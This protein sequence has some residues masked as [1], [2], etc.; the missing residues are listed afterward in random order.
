MTSYKSRLY[1]VLA[2]ILC[3]VIFIWIFFKTKSPVI[4]PINAI[5]V[6]SSI[7]IEF[8]SGGKN[9]K[10]TLFSSDFWN[11][12][13]NIKEFSDFKSNIDFVDSL[14]KSKNINLSKN[15]IY[16]SLLFDENK[17]MNCLWILG[18]NTNDYNS[19]IED[20]F[21]K[22][23]DKYGKLT[24][25]FF[26][27]TKVFDFEHDNGSKFSFS[28]FKGLILYSSSSFLVNE[29]IKQTESS[30]IITDDKYF[31]KIYKTAGKKVDGNL[32]VNLN[33]ASEILN[34]IS[35]DTSSCSIFN[36]IASWC[37][38]D[39]NFKKDAILLNGFTNVTDTSDS[40]LG[41]FYNQEPQDINI[42]NIL[43]DNA[44]FFQYYGFSDFNL[45]YD[46][47]S[48][49]YYK[50]LNNDTLYSRTDSF[51][52]KI[53]IN[54]KRNLFSWIV[55]EV[56]YMKCKSDFEK[57]LCNSYF[58][59]KSKDV[60]LSKYYLSE[61]NENSASILKKKIDT[62]NY[63]G[64]KLCKM[65]LS[66]F[67]KHYFGNFLNIDSTIYT[68][69]NN[70]AVFGNSVNSL[71]FI[72]DKNI[73]QK[74][75][76]SNIE[77][78]DFSNLIS[79][80][81]NVYLYF[82]FKN[83][84]ENI[85]TDTTLIFNDFLKSNVSELNNFGQFS[86]QF[87]SNND[88]Y[89]SNL[90]LKQNTKTEEPT[91]DLW[92]TQFDTTLNKGPY[93]SED[94]QGNKRIM[95]VDA[96]NQIYNVDLD[97]KIK[98]KKQIKDS[99]FSDIIYLNKGKRQFYLFNTINKIHMLDENGNYYNNYPIVLDISANNGITVSDFDNSKD[100]RIYFVGSDNVIYDYKLS[101]EKV[102]DWNYP[103]ID[104]I[105]TKKLN[106]YTIND[107]AYIISTDI[108]G[109]L[110]FFDR[111]GKEVLR[112]MPS[113]ILGNNSSI[114]YYNDNESGKIKLITT[115]SKGMVYKLSNNYR[116]ESIEFQNFSSEHYFLYADFNN[117]K[118]EDCIFVDKN[119][120]TI[121]D[122]NKNIIFKYNTNSD[123]SEAPKK[124][125]M[126]NNINAF[127]FVAR[128]TKEIYIIESFGII[129]KGFP[130][131]GRNIEIYNSK[132]NNSCNILIIN[133]NYL[134]NYAY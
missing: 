108:T 5:P 53:N 87:S 29:A 56:T 61:I 23:C 4:K 38:L 27:K 64:Y 52:K 35:K 68:F 62:L 124:F 8:P 79:S 65:P 51:M 127:T 60:N 96:K 101:S 75:L 99:I 71:K 54:I 72:I 10:N 3:L 86:I 14:I 80:N 31:E 15:N 90:C 36:K 30:A 47:Y 97:G 94:R 70:Y 113:I 40:Y 115:D 48:K 123:I 20:L 9:I 22:S 126:N 76:S 55:S 46:K 104:N 16:L 21:E 121:I 109:K 95:V 43:P 131:K 42:V 74:T 125:I 17:K 73:R 11:I 83:A 63:K 67:I 26:N 93:I 28:I 122:K 66:G 44:F 105:V 7:I 24:T 37:E 88:L 116:T 34:Y 89:Y 134:I 114:K 41:L 103:K 1:I 110:T 57:G 59:L 98:W 106:T 19:D 92:K 119:I 111:T 12:I 133:E 49:Y 128:K 85:F 77:Y 39:L 112:K 6:N 81:S 32:F 2:I 78:N 13:K 45:F 50:C 69:I 100:F 120:I 132:G 82:N 18:L 130:M 58:I 25:R 129:K 117:D 84:I 91:N 33:F 107:K 118:N 102:K